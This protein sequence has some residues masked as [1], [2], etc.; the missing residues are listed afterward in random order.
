MG[1][2]LG[3]PISFGPSSVGSSIVCPGLSELIV[4]LDSD[5]VVTYMMLNL[6]SSIG[7]MS[8]N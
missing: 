4:Y 5:N 3:G 2:N 6:M 1:Q 8:I 7:G